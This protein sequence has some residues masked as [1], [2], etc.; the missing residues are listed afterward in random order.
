MVSEMVKKKHLALQQVKRV[1]LKCPT[2][3]FKVDSDAGVRW[4]GGVGTDR[5][6]AGG[7]CES[8]Q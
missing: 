3:G 5:S 2:A 4:C 6:P 8:S 1:R 7:K